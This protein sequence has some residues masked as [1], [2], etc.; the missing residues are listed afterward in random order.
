M[1]IGLYLF[2]PIIGAWLAQASQRDMKLFLSL[3]IVT[4]LLPYI[5]MLAPM[6]GY[7]GNYGNMGL[8]GVCDWNSYGTFYYFS[9][10]LGYIVLAHYLMRFPLNWSWKK[11]FSIA[12]TLFLVG[13]AITLL[14]FILTQQYFPGE[15]AALEIIWCFSGINVFMMTLAVFLLISKIKISP[16]P[17]LS[18]IASLTFGVYLCHFIFVQASY[19]LIHTY[20]QAPPYLQ[21]PAVA[22][23]TFTVTLCLIG[24][25]SKSKLLRKVIG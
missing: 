22:I 2:I 5:Q 6:S 3:W 17:L 7:T 13:Y 1:L 25:M 24:L 18:K 12:I 10:F 9:G 21:I 14:G 23:F 4:L 15:Y 19:D 16:S 8:L 11:T 20:L